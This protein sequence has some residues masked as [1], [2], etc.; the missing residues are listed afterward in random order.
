MN[1]VIRVVSP[2]KRVDPK[3]TLKI[4]STQKYA[5]FGFIL[6][7]S[8]VLSIRLYKYLNLIDSKK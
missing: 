1:K 4:N 3:S 7:L 8:I 2:M 6:A 5:L